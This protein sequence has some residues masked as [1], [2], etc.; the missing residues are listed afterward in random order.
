MQKRRNSFEGVYTHLPVVAATMGRLHGPFPRDSQVFLEHPL[1]DKDNDSAYCHGFDYAGNER[2][3]WVPWDKLR[4]IEHVRTTIIRLAGK[5][6]RMTEED[7]N[8]AVLELESTKV[9]LVDDFGVDIE[10]ML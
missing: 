5:C 4:L 1:R 6:H 7:F 3:A 2:S 10:G 8:R 9:P